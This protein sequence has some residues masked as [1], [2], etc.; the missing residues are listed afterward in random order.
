MDGRT[1]DIYGY[2]KARLRMDSL[3]LTICNNKSGNSNFQL[4]R[5][6]NA[7]QSERVIEGRGRILS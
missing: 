6:L 2:L 5:S 1:L 4:G 3:S 7:N